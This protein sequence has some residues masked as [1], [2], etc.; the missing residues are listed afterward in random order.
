[1]N[2]VRQM[3]KNNRLSIL[4]AS[5]LLVLLTV[6]GLLWLAQH[7]SEDFDAMIQEIAVATLK[8]D[9][10]AQLYF[11][12]A[13]ADGIRWDPTKLT[14]LSDADFKQRNDDAE[15]L[16]K[17]LT[18]YDVAKLS[19]EDKLTYDIAKWG[20][21]AA[22][23]LYSDLNADEYVSLTQFP[24]YFAN[25]YPI[26]NEADAENY[27]AALNGFSDKVAQFIDRIQNKQKKG[28][29]PTSEFLKEMLTSYEKLRKTKPEETILY[30]LYEE[31]LAKVKLDPSKEEELKKELLQTLTDH[32]LTSYGKLADSI[33][34][35][36]IKQASVSQ[37]I[38]SQPGGSEYYSAR[39]GVVTGTDLSPLEIHEFAKRKA[40]EIVKKLRSQTPGQAQEA[41]ANPLL[42]GNEL[43]QAISGELAKT[44]L[45]LSDW[46]EDELITG[47]PVDVR[48]YSVPFSGQVRFISPYPWTAIGTGDFSCR[49]ITR[50]PQR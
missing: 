41:A 2:L 39:L 49:S 25:N 42:S 6:V 27:I 32:V 44:T 46:F 13:E 4:L 47:N 18:S 14:G 17:K 16:L 8:D 34:N 1:M 12:V 28:F 3:L 33:K 36:L 11:G 30:T 15:N 5:G 45:H 31:K 10:E 19:P 37:G 23:Q 43:L 35:D 29:V 20:L 38:W 40:E 9:S 24:P 26:R 7:E 22:L 48:S 50:F 21:R